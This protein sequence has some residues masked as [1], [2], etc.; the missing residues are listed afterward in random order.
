MKTYELLVLIFAFLVGYMLFKRGGCTEGIDGGGDY[1]DEVVTMNT[2]ITD[3]ITQCNTKAIPV[4]K[5]WGGKDEVISGCDVK[6]SD[7][8]KAQLNKVVLA[9]IR[10]G[11]STARE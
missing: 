4:C 10:Y 9:A 11:R 1:F 5:M 7:N 6:A 8:L 2:L 3:N